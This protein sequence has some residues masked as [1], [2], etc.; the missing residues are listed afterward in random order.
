MYLYGDHGLMSIHPTAIVHP[1][2]H[3]DSDVEIGPYAVVEK[4]VVCSAGVKI[5]PRAV[6]CEGLFLDQ[7]VQVHAG[8]V[9]AGIPQD[10]KF[11]GQQ[12][13][14][15]I[16]PRTVVREYCTL[17]RAVEENACTEIGADCLIM[18][19]VHIGHDCVIDRQV[20]LSNRVQ[21]GGHVQ[22]GACAV[23]GGCT[24]IHQFS[25]I[26]AYAFV[27]GTLKV[28]RD[29]PLGSKALGNP[30]SWA[31]VNHLGLE[32]AG[33]NGQD[34]AALE[35]AYRL[36]FKSSL[37]ISLAQAKLLQSQNP[38]ASELVKFIDSSKNGIIARK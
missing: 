8:A 4:G 28:D 10:L 17:N 15:R 13:F 7:Q 22:I 1:Q 32:R 26:G 18:A 20:V 36:L 12:S 31:G 2:A 16:G 23:V 25:R 34:L 24:A 30:L 5:G 14:L 27:G 35:A 33:V 19:Y 37:P 6:L 3:L 11:K 21:L 29:I 9:L 38:W